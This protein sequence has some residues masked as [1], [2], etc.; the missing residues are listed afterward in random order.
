MQRRA[1]LGEALDTRRRANDKIQIDEPYVGPGGMCLEILYRSWNNP[2][3]RT[4]E[5]RNRLGF[6]LSLVLFKPGAIWPRDLDRAWMIRPRSQLALRRAGPV[7]A[8]CTYKCLEAAALRL[9]ELVR[10]PRGIRIF[11]R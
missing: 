9:R 2:S 7:G 11:K 10:L 1:G 8:L 5:I 6:N 3:T 4:H